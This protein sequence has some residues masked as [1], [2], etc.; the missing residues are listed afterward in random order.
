MCLQPINSASRFYRGA[1]WSVI[2]GFEIEEGGDG[3]RRLRPSRVQDRLRAREHRLGEPNAELFHRLAF[4]RREVRLA[5]QLPDGALRLLAPDGACT[6]TEL[7]P[8]I[9]AAGYSFSHVGSAV[10]GHG[11]DDERVL[12]RRVSEQIPGLWGRAHRRLSRPGRD[13]ALQRGRC[14]PITFQSKRGAPME[15][16]RRWPPPTPM[17]PSQA[18]AIALCSERRVKSPG[19]DELVPPGLS[20]NPART[21]HSGDHSQEG[22]GRTRRGPM[23]RCLSRVPTPFGRRRGLRRTAVRSWGR[24]PPRRT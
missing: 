2:R 18:W 16:R 7:S 23:F 17:T 5:V 8:H 22:S 6:V 21:P 11:R 15:S 19:N 3:P 20:T 10:G 14:R 9:G 1:Q 13:T 24:R 4:R 12:E